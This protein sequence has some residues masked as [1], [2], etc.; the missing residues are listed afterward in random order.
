MT[1]CPQLGSP[2]LQSFKQVYQAR[3]RNRD[4]NFKDVAALK[5]R[6]GDV[7]AEVRV[8]QNLGS[9]PRLITFIGQCS[10]LAADPS[11]GHL[12]ITELAP[13]GSLSHV[14]ETDLAVRN[15]IRM[16][17]KK[18]IVQQVCAG[19]EALAHQNLVHRDLALRCGN[20]VDRQFHRAGMT[21]KF[22]LRSTTVLFRFRSLAHRSRSLVPLFILLPRAI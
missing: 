19:M 22:P 1:C 15:G 2:C 9:H 12:L 10:F 17:H 8:L 5:V 3:Y 18:T 20:R 6:Q 14:F 13:R 21:F 7:A 16:I 4:G 11:Q